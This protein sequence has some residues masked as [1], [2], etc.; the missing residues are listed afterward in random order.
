MAQGVRTGPTA[1]GLWQFATAVA[2]GILAGLL[3]PAILAAVGAISGNVY[4]AILVGA[5]VLTA[6]FVALGIWLYSLL[7]ARAR[8]AARTMYEA[9]I[10]LESVTQGITSVREELLQQIKTSSSISIFVQIG[11]TV[12]S[13]ATEYYDA[14]KEVQARARVR[15]LHA[16]QENPYLSD[17]VAAERNSNPGEWRLSLEHA[18][19]RARVLTDLLGPRFESR[20]HMEGFIWQLYLFD[21]YAYVQPYIYRRDNADSAPVLK[22]ARYE[23][24][25][26]GHR[27]RIENETSLYHVFQRFFDLKWVENQPQDVTLGTLVRDAKSAVATIV[28]WRGLHVFTIP[29]RY[30]DRERDQIAFTALGGKVDD[31]ESWQDALRREV[32]EEL[33]VTIRLRS[34]GSVTRHLVSGPGLSGEPEHLRLRADPDV[35]PADWIRPWAIQE[36]LALNGNENGYG[37]DIR[38]V[39]AYLGDLDDKAELVPRRE[40]AAV[41][42]LTREMLRRTI[43]QTGVTY[44]DIISGR[45]GSRLIMQPGVV[46]DMDKRA[47]PYGFAVVLAAD[48]PN[49]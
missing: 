38:W 21:D 16:S 43:G 40:I 17:R 18:E 6:T 24:L 25:S 31:G 19:A 26:H 45:D 8:V 9:L 35:N 30:L 34:A 1:P 33:G 39:I 12:F 23:R 3:V 46:F 27:D 47:V 15:I 32:Q 48:R 41:V 13:G 22:F 4:L 10:G 2:A 5:V 44:R 37:R 7:N 20:S 14:L 28:K 29:H 49:A 42:L 36:R 11:K